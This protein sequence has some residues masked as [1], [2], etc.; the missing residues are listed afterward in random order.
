MSKLNSLKRFFS[1][2]NS[3]VFLVSFGFLFI[4]ERWARGFSTDGL[5][6]QFWNSDALMQALPIAELRDK[7]LKSLWYLH[8]Q[9]PGYDFIRM[10][11]AQL[12]RNSDPSLLLNNVDSAMYFLWN[13]FFAGQCTLLFVWLSKLVSKRLAY[14]AVLLWVLYPG[15]LFCASLLDPTLLSSV[16]TFWFFYEL[17]KLSKNPHGGTVLLAFSS[18][19]MYY[20]RSFYQWYFFP[21]ALVALVLLKVPRQHLLKYTG[22]LV[23]SI[24]PFLVKQKIL[25]NILETSS[26][27]GYHY[28]GV[29]WF[30]PTPKQ[31][32]K[33]AR[34]I[35]FNYPAGAKEIHD[36]FNTEKQYQ[37]NLIYKEI[38]KNYFKRRPLQA[39]QA[40]FRSMQQNY[41]AMIIPVSRYYTNLMVDNLFWRNLLDYFSSNTSLLFFCILAFVH[42]SFDFLRL[43][44]GRAEWTRAA[45]LA[46]PFL[47][48]LFFI[49]V[50]NRYEWQET[51]RLRFIIDPVCYVFVMAQ[52][53]SLSKKI[54]WVWREYDQD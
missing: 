36:T 40:I 20:V 30:K 3:I 47:Y 17:W 38:C 53:Y 42:W 16:V 48:T 33:T 10:L 24:V 46:L 1:H 31:I 19:A 43:R 54:R 29:M 25:F 23:I 6:I 45:A 27:A 7:P 34:Q 8:K 35:K 32:E 51:N 41:S 21:V 26:I 13:V 28:C 15:A 18:V 37:E 14:A 4:L 9:A 2:P 49:G 12:Y 44:P 50:S 5:H 39:S 52:L 11:L 22:I